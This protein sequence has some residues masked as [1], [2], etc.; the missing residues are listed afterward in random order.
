MS[1]NTQIA[2]Q[3]EYLITALSL[4]ESVISE[5][6]TKAFDQNTVSSPVSAPDSLSGILGQDGG[7]ETVP[8]PDTLV[9]TSPYSASTP[10]FLSNCKFNDVDDYN[11]YQRLVNTQRAEKYSLSVKV[12]YASVTYPDSTILTKS[13][14]KQFKVTLKSPYIPDSLVISYAFF[15]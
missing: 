15:Y 1:A 6:K 2:E 7:S 8:S 11:G 5:A 12:A 13:Y 3:N 10:G 14:C 4:A 9:T